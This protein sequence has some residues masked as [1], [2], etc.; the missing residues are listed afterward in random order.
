MARRR[1][2][3][4]AIR[5][6]AAELVGSDAEHLVRVLR[7]EAGER[8]EISDNESVFLA[9]VQT[10]RK[11][12]VVFQ[13]LE[14]IPLQPQT[15]EITL[16]VALFKFDH[17]EW[18]IEKATELGVTTIRPFEGTRSERGLA[19]ASPKRL[20]RWERIVLEASQQSRRDHLPRVEPTARF[21]SAV[22]AAADIRLL[23]DED[24]GAPPIL[25]SLPAWRTL[26]Q[27]V[28][29]MLGPEGGWTEEER[30]MAQAV[31]W[32]PCSLAPTVLRAE[33]AGIGGLS[34]VTAAWAHTASSLA[35]HDDGM[36]GTLPN[37]QHSE[38]RSA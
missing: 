38:E 1:F 36:D 11:S 18:L 28:A 12:L 32:Q 31:G 16:L 14:P 2:F 23:L 19:Q 35:R 13:T 30:E 8:Y 20:A 24:R 21:R 15:V 17:L 29:L 9:E 22:E 5:R 6:G 33:T 34:I 3:V 10:A 25:Q 26:G 7:V 37:G 4:P 27:H